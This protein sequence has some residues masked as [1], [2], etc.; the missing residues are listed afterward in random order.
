MRAWRAKSLQHV[1]EKA[2][3]CR[4]RRS[5]CAVEVDF[6]LHVGLLGAAFDR[7]L[8][9]ERLSAEP[10][11]FYQGSAVFA[12]PAAGRFAPPRQNA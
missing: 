3:A 10:R 2:D 8:A 7:A 4:D 9:H 1:V 11:A 5:T 6:N 12:T